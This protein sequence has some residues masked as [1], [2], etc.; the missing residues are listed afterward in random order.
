MKIHLLRY[1]QNGFTDG[2][3]LFTTYNAAKKAAETAISWGA[4]KA[5]I[6][7]QCGTYKNEIQYEVLETLYKKEN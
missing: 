1:A 5:T 4:N 7:I 6:Y 3:R 2:I